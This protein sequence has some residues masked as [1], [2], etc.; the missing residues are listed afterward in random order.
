MAVL[1]D[2]KIYMIKVIKLILHPL[3][4]NNSELTKT[5]FKVSI[6]YKVTKCSLSNT[7]LK[8]LLLNK[9]FHSLTC[10]LLTSLFYRGAPHNIL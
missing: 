4:K 8:I 2:Q 1:L 6:I 10:L 9:L 3:R 7:V 5:V